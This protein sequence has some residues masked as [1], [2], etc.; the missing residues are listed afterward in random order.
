MSPLGNPDRETRIA[1]LLYAW[2]W[3]LTAAILTF[4][5]FVFASGAGRVGDFT[6]S[7]AGLHDPSNGSGNS[8]PMMFDPSMDIWFGESDPAVETYYEIEDRFVAEDYVMVTFQE[9]DDPLGVFGRESLQTV[10]RLTEQFLTVGGVRHVRSLTSN[11]WIRWGDIDDGHSVEKGLLISDLIEGDVSALSDDDLLV[12]MIAVLGAERAA[13]R[14]GEERV[15]AVLGPDTL[16]ADH[17]GEPRLL[18]TIVSET[19]DTT[20]IQVQVLRP[21][22]DEAGLDAAFGDDPDARVAGPKLHS[23]MVQR[24][25]VRGLE[26]FV[27]VERGLCVTTD[28]FARMSAE[29]DAL[30]DGEEKDARRLELL[31]PTRSMIRVGDAPALRKWFE[32]T[33]VAGGGYVDRSDPMDPVE[34]PADF[35]PQPLSRYEFRLGG[36]PFF[37]RNFEEVGL[38][39]AKF[40]PLM[41]LALILGLALVFR[42]FAGVVAPLGV[43]FGSIAAMIGLAFSRGDLLNNLTMMSPNMLTAVGIADAIHLVAAWSHLRHEIGDRRTLITEVIRRNALPVSLTSLTTAIGFYSLTVS[44]L[45]PVRML[46]SMAGLGTLF[47]YVLSM[48]LV[49]AILSL[50]PHKGVVPAKTGGIDPFN[51]ERSDRL[52]RTIVARRVPILGAAIGVFLVAAYGLSQIEIDSDFRRMFPDDNKTM[53]DFHWIEERMGG[54]GDLEIVF[55]GI[56]ASD[57]VAFGA[58]DAERLDALLMRELGAVEFPED[59]D[60]LGPDDAAELTALA[61]RESRWNAARIGVSPEFLGALDAF[62]GRLREEMA[63]PANPISAVSDLLSPLDILRKM[64]QV[65]HENDA[66]FYRVPVS[67]D[68]PDDIRPARLSYDEFTEEWSYTP[69]QTASQLMAQ[70]YLQY[71]NGARPGE[72]LA[73]QLSAKRTHFR[74]QGRVRQASSAI[75]RAAFERIAEIARTEF[76][77]L[78][79]AVGEVGGSPDAIANVTVS[80]KSVLFAR[81]THLFATGFVKSMLLALGLITLVIGLIFRSVRL[82]LVSLIPNVLPIIVPIS[83][84]GL[85]DVSLDGPAILVSSVALGVC[86]D[87][88]VHLFTKFVRAHDSGATA[89]EAL[90]A[91]VHRVGGALTLTTVLLVVGFGT[92]LLSDFAPNFQ[93][94]ALATVMIALAWFADF[95][96]TTAALSYWKPALASRPA[97]GD[98]VGATRATALTAAAQT[99]HGSPRSV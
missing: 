53:S 68:V 54:V 78:G 61:D 2:R 40:V 72:N 80:G 27:R 47:A 42:R 41:F 84:F 8:P 21:R 49:P 56:A 13:L 46:G 38:G 48:T 52:V 76:P 77:V 4:V 43:V 12:R 16:F 92:L 18:G 67:A 59:F 29:I 44:G 28:D 87:D 37:E 22:L 20:A 91:A 82:A 85:F 74:M 66:E 14:V 83:F 65:Q 86:V 90:A 70:Y 63:D 32:Y 71:E 34:A 3:P 31:D 36:V 58:D 81:T 96:L 1:R 25:S 6:S 35:T 15:R 9:T 39:D 60:P 5:A 10:A 95:V 33:P 62:E 73:T 93:M 69:P 11:P 57:D 99:T 97:D 50:V 75:H 55:E 94:G 24:S 51:R 26:H 19:G 17:I 30:P 64:H 23:V 79:A 7:L 89:E 98:T 88:T 45:E